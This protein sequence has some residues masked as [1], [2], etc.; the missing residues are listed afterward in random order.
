[1]HVADEHYLCWDGCVGKE[2]RNRKG[3]EGK[4]GMEWN[5]DRERNGLQVRWFTLPSLFVWPCPRILPAELTYSSFIPAELTHSSDRALLLRTPRA[6]Q[7]SPRIADKSI[8]MGMEKQLKLAFLCC[9]FILLSSGTYI[10]T[11]ICIIYIYIYINN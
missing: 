3:M 8:S 2:R 11:C 4:T 5:L 10:H 1:M 7:N 6:Q 9:F